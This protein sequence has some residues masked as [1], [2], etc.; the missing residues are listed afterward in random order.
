MTNDVYTLQYFTLD[1]LRDCKTGE[2]IVLDLTNTTLPERRKLKKAGESG[3]QAG[4]RAYES[5]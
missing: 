1:N 5:N 3:E 4:R 2:S